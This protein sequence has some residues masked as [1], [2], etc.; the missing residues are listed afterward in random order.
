MTPELAPRDKLLSAVVEHFAEHGIGDT[1]LRGIAE[2]VGTSHRML[3][4]HFGSREG[5]LVE[6]TRTVEARQRSMM[7]ATYDTAST[8]KHQP[9]PTA[10]ICSPRAAMAS[11]HGRAGSP[12]QILALTM[13]SVTGSPV[14]DGGGALD[15]P[16]QAADRRRVAARSCFMAKS[17]PHQPAGWSPPCT[18]MRPVVLASVNESRDCD[19][20]GNVNQTCDRASLA[21]RYLPILVTLLEGGNLKTP[22]PDYKDTLTVTFAPQVTPSVNVCGTP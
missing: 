7:T 9:S 8:K 2:A 15:P 1:S 6:V 16:V 10:A 22:S 11:A 18:L 3:I 17:I 19:V 5:L 13:A 21:G 12:V 4:Y 20:S 14:A